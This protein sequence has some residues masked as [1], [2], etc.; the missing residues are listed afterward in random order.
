VEPDWEGW[1]VLCAIS[2]HHDRVIDLHLGV[3]VPLSAARTDSLAEGLA[4]PPHAA[5]VEGFRWAYYSGAALAVL[6]AIS[7]LM[8][9]HAKSSR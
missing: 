8:L 5:L 1:V 9:I 4:H 2:D 6:G 7:T 3:L